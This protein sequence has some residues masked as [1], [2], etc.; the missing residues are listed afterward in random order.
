MLRSVITQGATDDGYYPPDTDKKI[1]TMTASGLYTPAELRDAQSKVYTTN[2]LKGL[3][4]ATNMDSPTWGLKISTDVRDFDSGDDVR[5]A[6]SEMQQ[7]VNVLKD[8]D[9]KLKAA[10]HDSG[11]VLTDAMNAMNNCMDYLTKNDVAKAADDAFA[12]KQALAAKGVLAAQD[13]EIVFLPDELQFG[14]G[15]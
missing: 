9:L 13:K 11:N 10:G 7:R 12:A 15:E 5:Q 6:I 3:K 2:A 1:A 14:L 4:S 8:L